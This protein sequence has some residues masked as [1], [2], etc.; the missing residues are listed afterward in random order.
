MV[1]VKHNS[2]KSDILFN[3]I[4]IPGFSGSRIFRVQVFQGPGFS[5]SGVRIQGPGPGPSLGS[6]SRVQVQGPG[7]GSRS[8]PGF[9]SSR[10]YLVFRV[11]FSPCQRTKAATGGVLCKR[12]S[13]KFHKIHRKKPVPE[14]LF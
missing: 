8:G 13:E 14:S 9:R 1:F 11:Y 2:L 4:F 6:G 5:G 12:C 7:P 3:P 10:R